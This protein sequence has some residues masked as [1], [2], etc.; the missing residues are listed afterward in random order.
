MPRIEPLTPIDQPLDKLED[1]SPR[2]RSVYLCSVV[3]PTLRE[4]LTHDGVVGF[5][6]T[7]ENMRSWSEHFMDRYVICGRLVDNDAEEL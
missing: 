5:L 6:L 1:L 3:S 7:S 2:E 4:W